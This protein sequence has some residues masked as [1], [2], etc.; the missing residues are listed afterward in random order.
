MRARCGGGAA[1]WVA[2]VLAAPGTQGSWP[3]EGSRKYALEGYDTQ[4]WPIR[5][6]ILTWRR[7][8]SLAGHSPQGC[9][10][11]DTTKATLREEAQD[12]FF[13]FLPVAALPQ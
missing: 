12:I 10:E 3:G 13:F 7:Q 5:S 9:K 4:Y 2:G 1:A 11:S 8:R 6:S